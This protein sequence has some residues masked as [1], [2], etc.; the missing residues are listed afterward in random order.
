MHCADTFD[1][2]LSDVP[3]NLVEIAHAIRALVFEVLPTATETVHLRRGSVD[4]GTTSERL[5]DQFAY[6]IPEP[7]AIRLGFY[8]GGSLP[9]PEGQLG[10][11]VRAA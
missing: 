2:I 9:D 11:R 5:R 7:D 6:L 4:W 1:Q 3:P 10:R 8:Y